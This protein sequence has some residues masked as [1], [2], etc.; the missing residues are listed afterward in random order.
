MEYVLPS[1]KT[2]QLGSTPTAGQT[3]KIKAGDLKVDLTASPTLVSRVVSSYAVPERIPREARTQ[4]SPNI[5][6][7][8]AAEDAASRWD[9]AGNCHVIYDSGH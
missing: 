6:H 4:I 7:I 9:A 5:R 8:G 1:T 3:A 2:I